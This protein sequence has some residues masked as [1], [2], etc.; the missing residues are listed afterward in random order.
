MYTYIYVYIHIYI[1]IYIYTYKTSLK[2]DKEVEWCFWRATVQA[3][4]SG[5]RGPEAAKARPLP[6]K[7]MS[8]V[9]QTK[10]EKHSL[11]LA[12]HFAPINFRKANNHRT[13]FAQA[14]ERP[15]AA[16]D[17]FPSGGLNPGET[18]ALHARTQLRTHA[19]AHAR[20]APQPKPK[21]ISR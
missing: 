10:F 14:N 4:K 12:A 9:R 19:R 2:A 20:N 7:Q 8:I 13:P 18:I 17:K 15:G 1:H 21:S 5:Q 16:R 11:H 6:K 3:T